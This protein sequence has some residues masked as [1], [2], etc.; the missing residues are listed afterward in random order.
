MYIYIYIYTLRLVSWSQHLRVHDLFSRF[1]SAK[2][3]RTNYS[4]PDVHEV[5]NQLSLSSSPPENHH[6]QRTWGTRL[7]LGFSPG[8]GDILRPEPVK[9]RTQK[10]RPS[11]T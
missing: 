9:T 10:K 11:A 3:S 7:S 5:L 6:L 2:T 4:L 1:G 8:P